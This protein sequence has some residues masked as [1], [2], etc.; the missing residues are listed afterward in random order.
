MSL[1]CQGRG[2][3][4]GVLGGVG[5]FGCR[6]LG[7]AGP[8]L[9]IHH[10]F[11]LSSSSLF[12]ADPPSKLYPIFHPWYGS[13]GRSEGFTFKGCHRTLVIWSGILQSPFRNTEGHWWLASGYRPVVPQ[14]VCALVPFPYG[15]SPVS[16]PIPQIWRSIG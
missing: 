13:G 16:S 12:N 6:P 15:D 11:S 4:I 5:V 9:W 2:L 7:G 14:P 3:F 10:P 8:A 1:A